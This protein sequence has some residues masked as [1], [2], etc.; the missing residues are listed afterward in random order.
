MN[1]SV[2]KF[3]GCV[4]MVMGSAI[5]AGILLLPLDAAGPGFIFSTA[6]ILLS[7][8][9]LTMTGL[10]LVEMSLALPENACTFSSMA[11]KT[12]GVFG[13]VITWFTFLFFLYTVLWAY[14]AEESTLVA[15][16]FANIFAVKLSGWMAVG[17]FTAIFGTAVFWSTQMVDDLNRG[18]FS[19]KGFLLVAFIGLMLPKVEMSKLISAHSMNLEH[20][21]YLLAALPVMICIFAYHFVIPSLRS[22]VGDQPKALKW[23]VISGTSASL[24]IYLLWVAAT[25]GAVPLFGE[26][27]FVS[28]TRLDHAAGGSDFAKIL[29]AITNS[30]IISWCV[31]G[32]F[33]VAMTTSFLGVALGLFDFL[34]DGFK[35]PNTR[36]GRLQTALLT[37]IPPFILALIWPH[38]FHMAIRWS[39]C[40]VA[41]LCIILPVLMVYHLRQHKELKSSYRAFGGNGLFVMLIIVGVILFVLPILTNMDLLPMLK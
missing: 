8:V 24:V 23:I 7:W 39:A 18:L 29:I 38:G 31:D 19:I 41:I 14:M 12:L 1:I 22:Y 5:G 17:L 9:L 2:G 6:T 27:S 4:M 33:N 10:F 32:F 37:F 20:S 13:R 30:K 34:A 26:N 28:L 15:G 40:F 36:F 35:R 21:K 25:L 16:L 3:I 11:E